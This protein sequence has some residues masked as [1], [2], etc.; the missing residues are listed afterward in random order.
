MWQA[1]QQRQV[2]S[3][4]AGMPSV[5]QKESLVSDLQNEERLLSW[6]LTI[7]LQSAPPPLDR[8]WTGCTLSLLSGQDLDNT[9]P[10]YKTWT[11][12]NIPL[13]R[14]QTPLKTLPSFVLRTWLVQTQVRTL[15]WY[16]FIESESLFN[17]N[18]LVIEYYGKLSVNL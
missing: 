17:L 1:T 9:Y 8:T 4:G 5:W 12:G 18:Q 11:G 15:D 6:Q 2:P 7:T 14:G 3:M 16:H 10:T 13:T